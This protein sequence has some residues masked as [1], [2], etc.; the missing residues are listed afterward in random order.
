M[1]MFFVPLSI[2]CPIALQAKLIFK[3]ICILKTGWY[4]E[5]PVETEKI[6]NLHDFSFD[7]Y[8]FA[9]QNSLF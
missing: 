3:K 8:L 1:N 9:D 4:S 2:L 6:G 7:R 5:V